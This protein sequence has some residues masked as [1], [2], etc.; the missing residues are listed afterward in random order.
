MKPSNIL[1][2]VPWDW[3]FGPDFIGIETMTPSYWLGVTKLARGK[4]RGILKSE[5]RFAS[6]QS[7]KPLN[8]TLN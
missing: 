4:A 5:P 7:S 6:V 2:L 8:V 3:Y 1:I